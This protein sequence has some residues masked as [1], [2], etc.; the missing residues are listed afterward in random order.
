M[1]CTLTARRLKPGAYDDFRAAWGR[2]HEER[3][4]L[5]ERWNP[6]YLTRDVNDEN[7]VLAFGIFNGSLE[8]LRTVQQEYA[9]DERRG[10]VDGF[11]EEILLD[12]AYEVI[13]QPSS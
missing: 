12:G 5:A 13:E 11:V 1:I 8:E 2:G 10:D 3:P 4:D 6:V 7:V 9:Y